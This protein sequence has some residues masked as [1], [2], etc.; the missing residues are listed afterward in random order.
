MASVESVTPALGREVPALSVSQLNRAARELLERGFA[1]VWVRGEVSRFLA[2]PSGHWY[3]TL[4]DDAACISAAMFR[5]ANRLARVKL[6]DGLEVIVRGRVSL[7]EQRG[8][9]QIIVEHVEPAGEGALWLA[10]ER[11]KKKL[12]AEGLFD[13]DRKRPLPLV[14]RRI[15]IATSPT[16]AAF[17][18]ILRVLETRG[19]HLHVVIAPCRVQ[20]EGAAED[21]VAALR[22]LDRLGGLDAII[23]G[24][25]GGS[26][27]DLWAFNDEAVARAIASLRVPVISAV[28]HEIDTTIADLV[29]DVRA[30]TPSQ[31]A[32]LVCASATEL[33]D[34]IA[35]LRSR[36]A[37]GMRA[38]CHAERARLVRVEPR[39][40]GQRLSARV[41]RLGQHVDNLTGRLERSMAMDIRGHRLRTTGLLARLSPDNL[42]GV[43]RR[44]RERLAE[45]ATR[46]EA[47]MRHRIA[48]HAESLRSLGRALDALSPLSVLERGY[49]VLQ[50]EDGAVVRAASEV[51]DH[52]RLVALLHQG[53]LRVEVVER[54]L[55]PPEEA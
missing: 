37:H 16:G 6:Q 33:C 38:T 14:P 22:R 40:V 45:R 23:V 28:G 49:A 7:Y 9:Y 55:P 13:A 44:R 25:G 27:E 46:L 36:L 52:Q 53:R 5:G 35:G 1:D 32:E 41:E 31:A 29:A 50:R 19:A 26:I 10:F 48:A 43:L 24:R 39:R 17:A 18:D 8:S 15:G 11:L 21:I 20:G 54:T 2:H 30:A 4:K 34:K 47:A 51:T 3:F 12:A 42:A